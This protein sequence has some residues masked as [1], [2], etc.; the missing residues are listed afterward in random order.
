MRE[1]IHAF[2][3]MCMIAI[4]DLFGKKVKPNDIA[5]GSRMVA[6]KDSL[7]SVNLIIAFALM[8]KSFDPKMAAK[9]PKGEPKSALLPVA[10]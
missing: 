2:I 1:V 10:S 8:T 7:V 5:E 9:G 6:K 3:K 4:L